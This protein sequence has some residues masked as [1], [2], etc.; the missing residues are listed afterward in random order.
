MLPLS[1]DPS[2]TVSS[3][4]KTSRPSYNPLSQTVHLLIARHIKR[5]HN[6]LRTPLLQTLLDRVARLKHLRQLLQ[7]AVLGLGEEKVHECTLEEVPEHKHQIVVVAN[8]LKGRPAAVL[9][10]GRRTGA[11][12]VADG[13][14]L[15]AGAGG[16]GFGNVHGLER[17]PSEGEDDAEQEDEGHS[18]VC[19][20]RVVGLLEG[21]LAGSGHDGKAAR[22]RDNRVQ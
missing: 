6:R 12:E 14:S 5:V 16:Q 19:N 20:R 2:V 21:Q 1:F 4:T 8:V 7:G 17:R 22:T 15:G 13:G 11:G 9:D 3:A 18:G 10:D